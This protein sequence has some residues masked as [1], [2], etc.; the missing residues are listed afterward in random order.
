[1]LTC[2]C[3][4][5]YGEVGIATAKV[6]EY[7]GCTAEFLPNQTCCG[8]PAFN[9]GHWEEARKTA[10]HAISVLEFGEQCPVVVPSGSCTA[11]IRE[12]YHLLFPDDPKKV[13]WELSEILVDH[14]GIKSWPL[15]GTGFTEPKKI[16][17]HRSCHGRGI[18]LGDKVEQLLKTIP[19]LEVIEPSQPEQC[20]GFG[21]AFCA[22]HGKIASEIG[23]EKLRCLHE[24]GCMD[25]VSGDMGC[26]MHLQTLPSADGMIFRHYSE[27]LA[28]S[29]GL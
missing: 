1:M 20:C 28:E 12:G 23:N 21:G 25:V 26:L 14:L 7:A 2:L 13:A 15:S 24:T 3:D 17:F 6:L 10:N 19:N 8:Q 5:L 29:A 27:I 22:T 16:V 11:M 9:S 18:G 4:A